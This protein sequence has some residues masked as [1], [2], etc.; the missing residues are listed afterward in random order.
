MIGVGE[1]G[2]TCMKY[3]FENYTLDTERRELRCNCAKSGHHRNGKDGRI[4]C[5]DVGM[6]ALRQ[7]CSYYATDFAFSL[8]RSVSSFASNRNSS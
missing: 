5:D 7:Q 3:K 8:A 1:L 2:G 6:S 4:T